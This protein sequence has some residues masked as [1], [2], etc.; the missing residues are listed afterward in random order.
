MLF[1]RADSCDLGAR[2][3][4]IVCCCLASYNREGK[5]VCDEALAVS[6]TTLEGTLT[7]VLS[8]Y[9]FT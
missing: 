6:Y 7:V 4:A 9:A 2:E 5:C 3:S 8:E 1:L